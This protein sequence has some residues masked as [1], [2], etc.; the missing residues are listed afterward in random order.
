M[1][2]VKKLLT[3]LR[4]TWHYRE[5]LW[6]LANREISQRYKQSILGYFWVILNP[7]FQLIVMSFV[8]DKIMRVP[9]LGVPFIIFLSVA[10]LPWNLFSASLSSSSGVLVG[11]SNLITKIYFPREILVYATIIAKIVDFLYSCL[12]LIAF[13]LIFK[14]RVQF[15]PLLWV[16][17]IFAIQLV[18]TTGISLLVAAFNL[19][20]RDVQY[21]LNLIILIWMYLTPVMYPVEIIPERYRFIFSL[22]PMSVIINAYREVIIGQGKP[23]LNS[24][25]LAFLV[26]LSVFVIGFLIFKKLEGKFA[27]YV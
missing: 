16:P 18:L 1:E 22:N 26:S 17:A 23:N 19:F 2:K 27:D 10:L 24:L 4:L 3:N 15:V 11:N 8:F 21:L 5:L 9:S 14:I 25:S 20:Y 13:L 12:V 7:L 6:N